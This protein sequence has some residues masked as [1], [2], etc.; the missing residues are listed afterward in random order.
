MALILS[1]LTCRAVKYFKPVA[2]KKIDGYI[3]V[4]YMF[5]INKNNLQS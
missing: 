2:S 5:E 1:Y 4:N 3:E